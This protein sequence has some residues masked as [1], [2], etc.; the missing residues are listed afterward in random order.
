MS[1]PDSILSMAS[2]PS[3]PPS[4]ASVYARPDSVA[5]CSTAAS[6]RGPSALSQSQVIARKEAG[7][8]PIIYQT[9]NPAATDYPQSQPDEPGTADAATP[10]FT[11]PEREGAGYGATGHG[12]CEPASPFYHETS[13]R[14]GR[15]TWLKPEVPQVSN[16]LSAL[17][18]DEIRFRKKYAAGTSDDG[19]ESLV[20][21]FSITPPTTPQHT[22]YSRQS[23]QV[24]RNEEHEK[25]AACVAKIVPGVRKSMIGVSRRF[26]HGVAYDVRRLEKWFQKIDTDGSGEVTVRKMIVGILTDQELLDLFFLLR[27]GDGVLNPG[28]APEAPSIFKKP[29]LGQIDKSDLSWIKETMRRVD[30]D[31]NMTMEWTEFVEFF[32]RTG[33]L[34]EY[35]TK[36]QLNRSALGETRYDVHQTELQKQRLQDQRKSVMRGTRLMRSSVRKIFLMSKAFENNP[37]ANADDLKA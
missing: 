15:S 5:S 34:L 24:M 32:R 33:L 10:Q 20:A 30:K 37:E 31:G 3:R 36:E 21:R 8:L 13:L 14:Q 26:P 9:T 12:P 2:Y 6:S 29:H 17:E 27:E 16:V 11:I 18:R 7:N 4:V 28:S 22:K 23:K 1:R 19:S 25:A 35:K